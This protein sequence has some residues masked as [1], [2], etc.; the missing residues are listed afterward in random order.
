MK[1]QM[2]RSRSPSPQG[3]RTLIPCQANNLREVVAIPPCHATP[4]G[5]TLFVVLLLEEADGEAFLPGKVVCG[6][7]ITESTIILSKD[8]VQAQ[9]QGILNTPMTANR[10]RES[11]NADLDRT[12]VVS[13]VTRFFAV[14]LATADCHANGAQ[15]LPFL[16]GRQ[17]IRNGHLIIRQ[18]FHATMRLDHFIVLAR[19][20]I[21]RAVCQVSKR[22][23]PGP[24]DEVFLDF[25]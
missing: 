13:Y 11:T 14:V 25:S 20:D 1:K 21:G 12:D 5:D 9:K 24:R 4:H 7:A 22:Y 18:R 6:V 23:C 10:L 17:S 15:S 2:Q 3:K 8:D 19:F 16:D